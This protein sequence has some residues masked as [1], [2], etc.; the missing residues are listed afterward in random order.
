MKLSVITSYSIHYTKL[1]DTG[2]LAKIDKDGFIFHA[3]RKREI[4]KV[5]GRRVSPKEIEEVIVS[6]PGVVDCTVS[7]IIV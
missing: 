6:I 7:S 2:D 5:G 4:I 3:A 1:Y